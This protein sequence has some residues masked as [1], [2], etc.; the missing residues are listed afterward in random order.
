MDSFGKLKT[1]ALNPESLYVTCPYNSS[2]RILRARLQYHLVKCRKN[3]KVR[4]LIFWGLGVPSLFVLLFA[5]YVIVISRAQTFS[6]LWISLIFNDFTQFPVIISLYELATVYVYL[7]Y[8]FFFY[9]YFRR[10]RRKRKLSAPW[11][12]PIMWIRKNWLNIWKCVP[13]ERLLT[14]KDI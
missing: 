14:L 3:A 7:Q 13:T 6:S 2:H 9:H 11:M 5:Q 8:Y 12:P 10:K 4:K 1:D